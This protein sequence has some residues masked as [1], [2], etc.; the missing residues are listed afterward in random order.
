MAPDAVRRCRYCGGELSGQ[1]RLLARENSRGCIAYCADSPTGQHEAGSPLPAIILRACDSERNEWQTFDP[2]EDERRAR[3][4]QIAEAGRG[5]AIPEARQPWR[6][7]TCDRCGTETLVIG[8]DVQPL[9]V[10]CDELRI[11]PPLPVPVK[12]ARPP[13]RIPDPVRLVAALVLLVTGLCLSVTNTP[14]WP[15][16][17][18]CTGLAFML[19]FRLR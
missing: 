11:L 10:Y 5:F 12:P 9:C 7:G 2:A 3:M 13:R 14:A 6:P 16:G 19:L 1:G 4:R 18:F 17:G 8:P 15:L